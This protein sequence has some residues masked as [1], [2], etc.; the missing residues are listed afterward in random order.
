MAVCTWNLED[1]WPEFYEDTCPQSG[2]YMFPD[3]AADGV[4]VPLG[5]LGWWLYNGATCE[6]E[7]GI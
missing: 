7:E 5:Y 1:K 2:S 3:C 6:S 4:D